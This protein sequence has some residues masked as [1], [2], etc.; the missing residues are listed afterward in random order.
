MS[1]VKISSRVENE[2]NSMNIIS[3]KHCIP[4]EVDSKLN[5]CS[6]QLADCDDDPSQLKK[7]YSPRPSS[8]SGNFTDP[9][10]ANV[11]LLNQ[12]GFSLLHIPQ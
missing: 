7:I 2:S 11:Q 6:R 9:G 5:L 3:Y 12:G 8:N 10:S 4:F 1:T